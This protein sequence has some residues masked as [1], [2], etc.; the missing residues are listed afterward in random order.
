MRRG[1]LVGELLLPGEFVQRG[2]PSNREGM[3]A[4][5][6]LNDGRATI[7]P[8]PAP[9]VRPAGRRAPPVSVA[10][11]VLVDE[12]ELTDTVRPEVVDPA[13]REQ[14]RRVKVGTR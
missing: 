14:A 5:S 13:L 11:R 4:M 1:G 7:V 8:M 3:T 12:R 9:S 6:A 10:V 2:R